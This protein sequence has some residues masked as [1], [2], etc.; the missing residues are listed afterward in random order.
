MSSDRSGSMNGPSL[1]R[2]LKHRPQPA[3]PISGA[4]ALGEFPQAI[5]AS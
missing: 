5:R 4:L 2:A 1:R 3:G